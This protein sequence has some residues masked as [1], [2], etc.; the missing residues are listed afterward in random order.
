MDVLFV[1][2]VIKTFLQ[3]NYDDIGFFID[4]KFETNWTLNRSCK[5]CTNSFQKNKNTNTY[6]YI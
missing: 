6:L 3:Y 2:P 4:C 5:K 1:L